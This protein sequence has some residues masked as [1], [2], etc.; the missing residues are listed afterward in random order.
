MAAA[1]AAEAPAASA[2]FEDMCTRHR[3][4]RN[5]GTHAADITSASIAVDVDALCQPLPDRF[6]VPWST[7]G[8]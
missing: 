1:A 2:P 3:T 8:P 7:E 4:V 5:Q 6:Y